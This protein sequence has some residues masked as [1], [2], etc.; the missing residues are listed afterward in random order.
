L[1]GELLVALRDKAGLTL[2]EISEIDLFADI[3]Y[4]SLSQIYANARKN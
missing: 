1:R 3:Q 4:K 2:K